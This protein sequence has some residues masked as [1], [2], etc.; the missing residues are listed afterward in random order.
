MDARPGQQFGDHL[1]VDVGVLPHV[2][3]RQVKA[4]DV[5]GFSKPCQAV[6]G[7]DCTAVGP[8]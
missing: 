5:H 4:E 6:V 2:Q 3:T 1:F 7:D 8:Q